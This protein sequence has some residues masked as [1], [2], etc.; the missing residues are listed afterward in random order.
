MNKTVVL[1]LVVVGGGVPGVPGVGIP[2]LYYPDDEIIR[3]TV[4]CYSYTLSIVVAMAL[5]N[6]IKVLEIALT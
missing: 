3:N 4:V 6:S 1:I 5:I 2:V